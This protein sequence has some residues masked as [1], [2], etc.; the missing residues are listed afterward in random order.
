MVRIK[1]KEVAKLEVKRGK[2]AKGTK[3]GKPELKKLYIKESRSVRNIADILGCSKD[4]VYRALKEYGINRRKHVEKRSQ[5]KEYNLSFLKKEI[6]LKGVNQVA[7][8]LGVHNT[9]LRRY[10]AKERQKE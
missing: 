10:L 4:K 9:T 2:P 3:P 6:R 1:Y 7:H 8:E 5:L